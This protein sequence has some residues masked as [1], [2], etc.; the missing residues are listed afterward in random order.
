VSARFYLECDYSALPPFIELP[1]ELV[2]VAFIFVQKD[3]TQCNI[4]NYKQ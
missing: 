2:V 3:M 1:Q 4:I